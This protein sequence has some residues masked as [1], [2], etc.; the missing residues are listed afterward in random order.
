LPAEFKLFLPIQ[1]KAKTW[2]LVTSKCSIKSC[3]WSG[4]WWIREK[5]RLAYCTIDETKL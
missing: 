5:S 1:N 3:E 4:K 2:R